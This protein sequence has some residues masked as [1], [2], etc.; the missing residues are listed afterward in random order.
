MSLKEISEQK[1]AELQFKWI[2]KIK[3]EIESAQGSNVYIETSMYPGS[4]MYE[5]N[6]ESN[7]ITTILNDNKLKY[8]VEQSKLMGWSEWR[9]SIKFTIYLV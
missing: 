3:K 4:R 8:T 2:S 9:Y 1:K 7:I 6:A 5:L